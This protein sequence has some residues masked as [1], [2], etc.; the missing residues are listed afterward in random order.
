ML[1]I[2]LL[3]VKF[4]FVAIC[5]VF[6]GHPLNVFINI[7]VNDISSISEMRMVSQTDAF[8][9]SDFWSNPLML[10]TALTICP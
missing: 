2:V 8:F 10:L 7:N 3:S 6:S 4:L 1:H 9:E 5:P